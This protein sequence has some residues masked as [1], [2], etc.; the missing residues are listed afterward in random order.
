MNSFYFFFKLEDKTFVRPWTTVYSWRKLNLNAQ[1]QGV[2]TAHNSD[3]H[4][5]M[6]SDNIP[7]QADNGASTVAA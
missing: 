7:A 4:M 3:S 6:A 1:R 5:A 2:T